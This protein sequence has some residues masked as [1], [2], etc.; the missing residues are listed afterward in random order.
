MIYLMIKCPYLVSIIFRSY[1]LHCYTE[2]YSVIASP[3]VSLS[4]QRSATIDF[5]IDLGHPLT[6]IILFALVMK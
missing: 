4:L 6:C 5:L 2:A 3:G 1:H